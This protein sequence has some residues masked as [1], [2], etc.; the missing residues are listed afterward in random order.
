MQD[1]TK[2]LA[3]R[4]I[5]IEKNVISI[6][7]DV[8]SIRETS[9]PSADQLKDNKTGTGARNLANRAPNKATEQPGAPAPSPH[10]FSLTPLE[11]LLVGVV[12]ELHHFLPRG[13]EAGLVI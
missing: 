7:L 2:D 6:T 13:D 4:V 3:W 1:P 8:D 9:I 10:G 11:S 5:L 12:V